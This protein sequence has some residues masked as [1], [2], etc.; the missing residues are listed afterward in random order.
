MTENVAPELTFPLISAYTCIALKMLLWPHRV[1][2][3]LPPELTLRRISTHLYR[4]QHY[5]MATSCGEKCCSWAYFS[6]DFCLHASRSRCSYN[7]LPW[8]KLLLLS[9]PFHWFLPT[10]I[11]LK[12]LLLPPRVTENL[13]PGLTFRRILP[14]CIALK[15]LSSQPLVAENVAPDL[16]FP[17]MSAYLHRAHATSHHQKMQQLIPI[18]VLWAILLA[19]HAQFEEQ[20]RQTAGTTTAL[21]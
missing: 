4:P 21:T 5:L 2:E 15:M 10:C 8:R 12:M 19:Q 13:P 6:K 14:T 20:M 9:L 11:A 17:R 18:V 7:Q 1:T 3:N 16:T